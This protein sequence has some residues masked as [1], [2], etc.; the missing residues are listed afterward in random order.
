[1]HPK[2]VLCP[3]PARLSIGRKISVTIAS[4]ELAAG[5]RRSFVR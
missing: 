2:R 5:E 1:M 4:D 3:G